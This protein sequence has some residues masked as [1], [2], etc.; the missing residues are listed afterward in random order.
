MR[1]HFIKYGLDKY[2]YDSGDMIRM[3]DAVSQYFLSIAVEYLPFDFQY[4]GSTWFE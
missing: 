2:I 1:N 4:V 3:V